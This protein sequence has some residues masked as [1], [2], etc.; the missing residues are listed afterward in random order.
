[1]SLLAISPVPEGILYGMKGD[2]SGSTLCPKSPPSPRDSYHTLLSNEFIGNMLQYSVAH[3]EHWSAIRFDQS[4][5]TASF[6]FRVIDLEYIVKGLV[7]NFDYLGAINVNCA[8]KA[9]GE[10]F[11]DEEGQ[12]W[13]QTV[14][15]DCK[16]YVNEGNVLFIRTTIRTQS[17]SQ[18]CGT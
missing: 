2:I 5:R 10:S 4:C 3:Y 11:I 7:D 16:G 17:Y 8:I 18:Y 1:M 12:L 13:K 14:T 9:L 15:W 6:K